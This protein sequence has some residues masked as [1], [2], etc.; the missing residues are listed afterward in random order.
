MQKR[1]TIFT[2]TYN[3]AYILH[4][5]YESLCKQTNKEFI[6]L[7]VDDG[8]SDNTTDMV[9]KWIQEGLILIEY[10]R[11][12][13]QGKHI[14]HNTGVENCRTQLFFC[15]DSDDYLLE[16]A[17]EDI[18]NNI[19]KIKGDDISGIVSVRTRQDG[20]VIGTPMPKTVEYSSLSELYEKYKFK[21]DT[22]LI[23]KTKVLKKYKFPKIDNEKFM[24][25]E[26]IY[27]QIDEKHK[28]YISHDKYYVCEYLQDGYTTNMFKVIV[29]SPK[30]YMELKRT[31]LKVSK[32]F[33]I[34]YKAASLYIVGCWLSKER[35]CV[36]NSPNKIIT[37]LAIPLA[38]IVYW[39]RFKKLILK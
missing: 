31:K 15:V 38:S 33:F 22:A 13:N 32:T 3:R 6:W 4:R 25:E 23:F 8:S 27:A 17:I 2:P 20:T 19:G 12:E 18:I 9:S 39:I 1:L 28:L 7:I 30:G 35:S 37:I 10:I 29:N 14:A 24:G 5:L 26:Y 36:K 21:G 11:Q 34:K 16:N